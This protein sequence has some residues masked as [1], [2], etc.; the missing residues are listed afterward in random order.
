MAWFDE[1]THFLQIILSQLY[2]CA[3]TR[4]LG[5]ITPPRSLSTRWRVDS[6]MGVCVCVCVKS[7]CVS[8]YGIFM[9]HQVQ[10]ILNPSI[11]YFYPCSSTYVQICRYLTFLDVV[12]TQ[13]A[14][15]LQL[16]A[17]KDQPL[18][19]RGNS[20]LVLDLGLDI[21]NGVRRLNLKHKGDSN[22]G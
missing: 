22:S 4:M 16:L 18:L 10:L 17:S 20:L 14:S 13:S 8:E 21:L 2:F 3:S 5:S 11:A 12:I 19:V 9:Y 1:C 15:I 7:E 6:V